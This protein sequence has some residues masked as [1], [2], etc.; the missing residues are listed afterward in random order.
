MKKGE[1]LVILNGDSAAA[2]L[3]TPPE[4]IQIDGAFGDWQNHEKYQDGLA[5]QTA[6]GNPNI[7]LREYST[8]NNNNDLSFYMK[9]DGTIM[10]GIDIPVDHYKYSQNSAIKISANTKRAE[11]I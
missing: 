11:V 5:D 10:A 3:R 1:R 6:D 2:Y 9:V 4:E 8:I 7:D